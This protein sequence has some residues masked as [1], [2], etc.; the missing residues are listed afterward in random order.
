MDNAED[1]ETL[2]FYSM[3]DV[4]INVLLIMKQVCKTQ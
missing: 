1:A 2:K 4:L 3:A